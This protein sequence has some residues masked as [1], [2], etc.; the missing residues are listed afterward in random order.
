MFVI[1]RRNVP[2]HKTAAHVR[3]VADFRPQKLDPHRI[4]ISIGGSKITVE[5]DV[6]T[7][8]AD[9]STAKILIHQFANTVMNPTTGT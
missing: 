8:T 7:P 1:Q 3:M 2:A 6:D 9:L 5:Y 4:R